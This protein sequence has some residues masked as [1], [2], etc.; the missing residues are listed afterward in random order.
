MASSMGL[1]SGAGTLTSDSRGFGRAQ[2]AR[3]S[4]DNMT[5]AIVKTR[6]MALLLTRCLDDEAAVYVGRTQALSSQQ[7][8]LSSQPHQRL[9]ETQGL[10]R[11]KRLGAND[12]QD[13]CH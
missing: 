3:S 1:P 7:S 9:V 5:A 12:C 2:L 10:W 13:I 11:P 6:D 8:A 4:K